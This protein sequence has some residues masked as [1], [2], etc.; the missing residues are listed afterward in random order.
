VPGEGRTNASRDQVGFSA[1]RFVDAV[2]EPDKVDRIETAGRDPMHDRLTVGSQYQALE[3]TWTIL[4]A[5]L[6]KLERRCLIHWD[7]S[8]P[9][10]F[11]VGNRAT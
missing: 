4:T 1:D 7:A 10:V 8:R 9:E 2:C 5:T 6:L 3:N 11:P